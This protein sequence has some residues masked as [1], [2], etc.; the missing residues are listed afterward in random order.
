MTVVRDKPVA[1][2]TTVVNRL[3]FCARPTTA[4]ALVEIRFF[5]HPLLHDPRFKFKVP[6]HESIRS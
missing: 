4:P 6:P 1:D 3:G 2:D 5:R